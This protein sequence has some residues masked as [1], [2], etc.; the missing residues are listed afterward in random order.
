MNSYHWYIWLMLLTCLLM[1][2]CKH[3]PAVPTLQSKQVTKEWNRNADEAVYRL[4]QA[5]LRLANAEALYLVINF[6]KRELQLKLKGAVVWDFPMDIGK[7]DLDKVQQF[8]LR[9]QDNGKQ[10]IRPVTGK[11]LFASKELN[12]DSV[13][14]IISKVLSVKAELL[15]RDIPQRFL[16]KWGN[17]VTL[18]I[19]TNVTGAPKSKFKNTMIEVGQVLNRPFGEAQITITMR[20]EAAITFW[21]AV[22]IGLPTLIYPPS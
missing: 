5:E 12:S 18:D 8:T 13:L 20:P 14:A 1:I 2:N 19:S 16:V 17:R 22:Q 7:E 6:A 15:Q 10:V 9:F 4:A 3:K 21:R 11:H